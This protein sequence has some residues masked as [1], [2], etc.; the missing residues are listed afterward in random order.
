[1]RLHLLL[2]IALL[3]TPLAQAADLSSRPFASPQPVPIVGLPPGAGNI[4]ISI[5]EPFISRDGRFLFFNS[6]HREGNKDLHFARRLRGTW[7]YRGEIGPGINTP[8][9]VQGNPTMDARG[10][11][12]FID[13]SVS[14]MARSGLFDPDSGHVDGLHELDFL[15][16]REVH[17]LRQRFSGNMGVEISADGKELYYS[18]ATWDLNLWM[19]GDILAADILLCVRTGERFVCNEEQARRIMRN[20][21][22]DALE[23]AAALS[24]NGLELFFTRMDRDSIRRGRPV[25]R[26]MHARRS[27]RRDP[28]GRPTEILAIGHQDFVEGPALNA[29]EH[30]LYYHKR[31]GGKFRLFRVRR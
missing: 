15:P 13:T 3:F 8:K 2:P 29:D 6:G 19:P 7:V 17:F 11:F 24:R 18:R 14:H 30:W 9:Q 26:I 5:E 25:S 10:H 28:F 12:Y 27:T 4:P 16:D 1:M 22:T 23:Y 21:N 20:I 31:V